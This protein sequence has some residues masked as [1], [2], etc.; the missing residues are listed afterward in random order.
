MATATKTQSE[1]F[2]SAQQEL[3][4]AAQSQFVASVKAQQKIALDAAALWAE[5]FSRVAPKAPA[6]YAAQVREQAAKNEA[7]YDELLTAHREFAA[8]L[9]DVVVPSV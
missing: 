4:D 2:A 7:L 9:L 3:V 5:Q 8:R 1:Q 6:S